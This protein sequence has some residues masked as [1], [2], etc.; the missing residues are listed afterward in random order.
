VILI[1]GERLARSSFIGDIADRELKWGVVSQ[2]L[3]IV[4]LWSFGLAWLFR[5]KLLGLHRE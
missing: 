3:S 4:L 1:F 2:Y 5:Q